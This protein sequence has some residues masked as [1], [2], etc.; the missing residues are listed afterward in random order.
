ME[1]RILINGVWYVKEENTTPE[2]EIDKSELVSF[3]GTLYETTDYA[4][5]AIRYEDDKYGEY[6]NGIDIKFTDKR[7]QPWKEELWDNNN[8]FKGVL[9]NNPDSLNDLRNS[10]CVNGEAQFK[11]FLKYLRYQKW[12]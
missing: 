6:L 11:A 1:D 7:T 8:F 3:Q 10:V 4:F 5:E 9:E 2:I 12:I